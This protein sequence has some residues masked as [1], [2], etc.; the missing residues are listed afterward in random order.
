MSTEFNDAQHYG[1]FMGGTTLTSGNG[2]YIR[3]SEVVL[4]SLRATGFLDNMEDGTSPPS[5]LSKLWLDKNSD[6]AVLKEWNPVGAAWEQVTSQTLFG[7][8]PWRGEWDNSA[9][10][11]RAD[12]VRYQGNIWIA[13]QPSQNQTPAENAYWDL[14]IEALG[15]YSVTP[16]KM[17]NDFI[18]QTVATRTA[19]KAINTTRTTSA[20]LKEAGREGI[21]KWTSGDYST[22]IAADTLEG[23]YVKATAIAATS[24][25]W[26][27]QGGWALQGGYAEWFGAV[28]DY[29]EA[30]GSG[31]DNDAPINSALSLLPRVY[32]AGGYYRTANTINGPRYKGLFYANGAQ[33]LSLIH[34]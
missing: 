15:D 18:I 6:P 10:Y 30:D 20:Y 34:I 16:E 17:A 21:F 25:A 32:L 8:V 23:L 4:A 22:Q 11:R 28:A 24:G 26:V 33:S 9:I 7:R 31:T 13:V 2:F 3:W 14:F 1:F 5:D 27:R 19:L 12:V 29:D